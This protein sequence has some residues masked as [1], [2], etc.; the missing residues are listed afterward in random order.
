MN[1][2]KLAGEVSAY[3]IDRD[4]LETRHGFEED[5][6]LIGLLNLMISV[7]KHNPTY[8]SSNDSQVGRIGKHIVSNSNISNYMYKLF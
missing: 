2:N 1:L 6:G 3:I 7:V 8:K 4:Y 5:D